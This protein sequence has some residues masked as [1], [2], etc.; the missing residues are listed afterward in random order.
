MHV[1]HI[2]F[3]HLQLPLTVSALLFLC[4]PGLFSCSFLCCLHTLSYLIKAKGGNL[5]AVTALH[6]FF[7][8]K[9]K[10]FFQPLSSLPLSSITLSGSIV[11]APIHHV[12]KTQ[13]GNRQCTLPVGQHNALIPNVRSTK[14][15]T[16]Q[17]QTTHLLIRPLRRPR[18]R[19]RKCTV[20]RAQVPFFTQL[21]Q[22]KKFG[23]SRKLGE[24]EREKPIWLRTDARSKP[25][26]SGK[27]CLVQCNLSLRPYWYRVQSALYT[28]QR[29]G[30]FPTF[31]TVL[32]FHLRKSVKLLGAVK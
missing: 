9:H 21:R 31:Q 13:C 16:Y 6:L 26:P 10:S 12:R 28:R 14:R 15:V 1:C 7:P 3:T 30:L 11:L 22:W 8:R 27:V 29:K 19:M 20:C 32:N 25:F 5:F 24:G 17:P 4:S 23:H 18:L 2:V